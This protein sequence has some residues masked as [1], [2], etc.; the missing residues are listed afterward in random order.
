MLLAQTLRLVGL[1]LGAGLYLLLLG[2]A[3]RRSR[4]WVVTALGAGAA[5]HAA[6]AAALF[7]RAAT[8]LAL[9]P[10]MSA[11]QAAAAAGSV[12]AA[13]G[14]AAALGTARRHA[15]HRRRF[16]LALAAGL[17]ALPAAAVTAGT[18]S[19]ALVFAALLPGLSLAWFIYRYNLLGLRISPRLVFAVNLGVVFAVYL[20]LVK[21]AADILEDEF[22]AFRSLVELA[23]IFA[24]TLIWLPLYGWMT[25]SLSQRTQLYAGF[26]K[27]LIEEAARKLE[28]EERARFL[29][30][31]VARTF[32]LKRVMLATRVSAEL[33][34]IAERVM[35]QRLDMLHAESDPDLAALGFTYLF[36]LWYEDR[37]NGLLLLDCSPRLY[38]E[39]DEAILLGLS[40]QI[41]HSIETCRVVD[42][43]IRLERT[44][45]QQEHLAG[46]GKVAATIAHEIKNPLSS[47]KTLVQLMGEDPAVEKQYGRDLGYVVGEIDRLNR[48]VQ[49]LLTFSRPAPGAE[50]EVDVS[51]L[52]EATAGVLAR[53]YGPEGIRIEGRIEP[54][55]RVKRASQEM[56][57][58]I[59]LNLALNAVQASRPQ[60]RVVL[61]AGAAAG[62][63]RIAV[64]DQGA[65]IAP[66]LRERIFEPFF[67][68]KQKGTGLGLAIVRKNVRQLG[69]E[70]RVE[71]PLE[72]G[73]GTRFEVWLPV[74]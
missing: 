15:G 41:S 32:N 42:D 28:L 4:L 58:Q 24:A 17:A 59:V 23:L 3:L 22:D 51:E 45:A 7:L 48:S 9:E 8:G 6:G 47:I 60:D 62:K 70:I 10:W 73:H 69:G 55:L 16:R 36:A 74:E 49:Q 14:S 72:D 61:E 29:K 63:V 43:K 39:E 56:I 1:T 67:T 57:Q 31:E 25:R 44:L 34:A 54:Q 66:E 11:L 68:T 13:A 50:G 35:Q 19:A 71:S 12:L 65:G 38:L 2:M 20:L 5:W 40:R 52:L 18:D 26:S 30:A 46:L 27:R 37:L 33:Q 21:R 53:E 64:S